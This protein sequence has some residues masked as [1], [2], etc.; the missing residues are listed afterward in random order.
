[1]GATC[2]RNAKV[3]AGDAEPGGTI[4]KVIYLPWLVDDGHMDH[5]DVQVTESA[6]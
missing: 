2:S 1:M 6:E 3:H 5:A 4:A